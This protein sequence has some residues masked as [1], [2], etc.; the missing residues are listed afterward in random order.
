[1][2]T[3][4]DIGLDMNGML[5][6]FIPRHS[7]LAFEMNQHIRVSHVDEGTPLML[8]VYEGACIENKNNRIMK[9]FELVNARDGIFIIQMKLIERDNELLVRIMSDDI[10]LDDLKCTVNPEEVDLW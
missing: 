5:E 3:Q 1:M 4:L 8:N 7:P 2:K 9:S 6:V 10:I